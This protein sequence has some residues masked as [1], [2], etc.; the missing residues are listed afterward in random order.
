MIGSR[1]LILASARAKQTRDAVTRAKSRGASNKE[2][3]PLLRAEADAQ[4]NHA[5]LLQRHMLQLGK[6]S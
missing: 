3:A 6:A 4:M 5:F 1:E 2:L